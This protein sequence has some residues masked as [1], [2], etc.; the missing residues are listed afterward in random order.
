LDDIVHSVKVEKRTY[1]SAAALHNVKP[2]LVQKIMIS[3]KND[4]D[5]I[6]KRREKQVDKQR[7]AEHVVDHVMEKFQQ[8]QLIISSQSI[9]DEV[10]R[11]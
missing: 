8:R 9:A 5:F 3:M 2:A 10:N 4:P 6:N 1:K 7:V 11:S